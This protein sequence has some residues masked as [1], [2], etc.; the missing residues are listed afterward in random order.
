[1]SLLRRIFGQAKD[2]VDMP[3]AEPTQSVN[4]PA[5]RHLRVGHA[6]DVGLVRS[7]N[8]D[9]LLVIES[10]FE[11][12]KTSPCLLWPMAWAGIRRAK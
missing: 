8:E 3:V 12:D 1:M 11:G 5:S 7:H 6:S 9:V 4:R 10:V 2:S